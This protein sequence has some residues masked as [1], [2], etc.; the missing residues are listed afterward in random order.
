[1]FVGNLLQ[2]L[3]NTVDSF[4]VGRFLGPEALGAVSISFPVIFTLISLVAGL[5]MASTTMVAQYRGAGDAERVRRSVST[6]LSAI[7]LV[8]LLSTVVG[9]LLRYEI[10]SLMR[11]PP[12]ILEPAALYLGIF[13]TGLVPMFL[14]NAVSA[15]LRGLGDSVTPLRYLAYATV[16]NI[17]LDP[18]FIFGLGPIPAMGIR[19]VALATVLAQ[20][21]A[22]VVTLRYLAHGTDLL[23]G[24]ITSLSTWRLDRHLAY[25]LFRIGI[26][27][28]LQS[29]VVSF[30]MMIL[31]AVV[32]SFGPTTVAAFGAA[33]RLDQFAFLPA[34]SVSFAATALV[35][36]NL[37]AQ[38]ME[39]VRET[40]R[41]SLLLAGA[42]TVGITLVA[43]LRPT[44][45]LV[46]FTQDE[47]VIRE[48][49]TYLRIV[50][51]SYVPLALMFTLSGVL[52]GAGDTMATMVI[53]LLTLW[54]IRLPLAIGL[55]HY[56]GWGVAGAWWSIT[57]SALAGL[58]LNALYYWRGNWQRKALVK[59]RPLPAEQN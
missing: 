27:A 9:I 20:L 19:G 10:L 26:P 46:I 36:Q 34:F 25:E 52:R 59:P 5:T 21:I 48:G 30:A 1:M 51:L 16:L 50:G 2:A 4:W 22:T 12:A 43:L 6:S 11:T 44:I 53:S 38:K 58:A 49:I 35:G 18:L 56:L 40:V 17:V 32:N 3:Y 55:S 29:V 57:F 37:G 45:L 24:K 33:S 47:G 7:T 41:W 42:I 15:I 13:L 14:F 31:T 39:R 8:G 28:G 54:G 23:E